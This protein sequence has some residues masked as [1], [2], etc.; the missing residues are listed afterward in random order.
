MERSRRQRERIIDRGSGKILSVGVQ[1][2]KEEILLLRGQEEVGR[3][4]AT[5]TS[6]SHRE[7]Y[8]ESETGAGIKSTG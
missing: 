2:R 3:Q 6:G 4:S 7:G 5:G 8:L 1:G